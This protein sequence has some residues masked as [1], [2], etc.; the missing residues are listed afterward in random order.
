MHSIQ[1]HTNI[2]AIAKNFQAILLDAYGVFWGGNSKGIF[3]GCREV[4]EKL[5]SEGKI[6]GIVL[7]STQLVQNEIGKLKKHGLNKN[8]HYHFIITSGEVAKQIFLNQ[9]LPFPIPNKK[10]YLSSAN[11]PKFAPSETIFENTVFKKTKTTAE[12]DFIYLSIPHLDGKDQTDLNL[13]RDEVALLVQTQLPIVCANPDHFAHEGAP[14]KAVIRQ[15][16]LAKLYEELG[17][18]VFYIGKPGKLMFKMAMHCLQPYSI[19]H[20]QQILMVGDTP[21]TDIRGANQFGISS[22]LVLATGMMRDRIAHYGTKALDHLSI[23]DTP[24]YFINQ[25][26]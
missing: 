2:E 19:D 20:L 16:A 6:I 22:A 3:S 5:V 26:A 11:H 17:G 4:M 15:G 25:L 13:F 18:K 9:K 7:N 12:A 1:V 24:H 21:E 14:P 8:Q 23:E 10:F